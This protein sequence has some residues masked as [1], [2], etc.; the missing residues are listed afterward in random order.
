MATPQVLVATPQ[1]LV[2]TPQVLVPTLQVLVTRPSSFS[3]DSSSALI[4]LIALIVPTPSCSCCS[5][6]AGMRGVSASTVP[7]AER[8][9]YAKN[10][11]AATWQAFAPRVQASCQPNPLALLRNRTQVPCVVWRQKPACA[12]LALVGNRTQ[13]VYVCACKLWPSQAGKKDSD[14]VTRRRVENASV[15]SSGV[16]HARGCDPLACSEQ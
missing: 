3:G 9:T 10:F 15:S 4:A 8:N 6:N 2:P 16:G 13:V 7:S 11:V 1:V 14:C 5:P 12:P